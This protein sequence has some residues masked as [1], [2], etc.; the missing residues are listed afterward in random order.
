MIEPLDVVENSCKFNGL[1]AL[2]PIVTAGGLMRQTDTTTNS[3]RASRTQL[4]EDAAV[5]HCETWCET[6]AMLVTKVFTEEIGCYYVLV[7]TDLAGPEEDLVLSAL[8]KE[9][10]GKLEDFIADEEHYDRRHPDFPGS[11]S[12]TYRTL[13]AG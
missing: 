2:L 12:F 9:L 5:D 1:E 8:T 13:Y 10:G 7:L 4:L 3:G 6:D 11:R